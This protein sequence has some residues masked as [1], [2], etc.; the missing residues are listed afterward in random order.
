MDDR[1]LHDYFNQSI[2][3]LTVEDFG[4]TDSP[5]S[6]L[7]TMQAAINY[8][9]SNG[10]QLRAKASEYVIDVSTTGVKIPSGFKCDFNNATIFRNTGN[11]T[12]HDMWAN[13]DPVNGNLGIDIHNV[14]FDGARTA[15]SLNNATVAHRFCGL[16]LI[17]CEGKLTGVRADNTVN[18]EVQVE[19]TRGGI[20]LQSSVFMDCRDIRTDG[21][22]GTGLFITG[23]SGRL[24]NFQSNNNTGSGISGDQPG[25]IMSALS[26]KGSGYSGISLNG[27]GFIAQGIYASGAPV[28]FAGVNFGHATPES[29]NGVN[30]VIS[31]IIVENNSG[32]GINATSCPGITISNWI[33]KG[34]GIN[35]LRLVNC[36]DA[37]ISGKSFSA[38]SNGILIDGAGDYSLDVFVLDSAGSGVY[39]RNGADV[40]FAATSVL[41]HN[42]YIGGFTAE[43]NVDTNSKARF[44]GK[45]FNGLAFGIQSSGGGTVNLDGCVVMGN[46]FGNTRVSGGVINYDRVRFSNDPMS[47]TVVIQAGSLIATVL[48]GNAIDPNHIN[49]EPANSA[50]RAAGQALI[51][52]ITPGLSFSI[53]VSVAAAELLIYRWTLI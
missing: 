41:R 24:I 34:S 1:R 10:I 37:S 26:S 29:S 6:T 52:N 45:A 53:Q 25:W 48:N 14:R 39:V 47:G 16:R 11:K 3:Y 18:A 28:G 9:A 40:V 43:L 20:L 35:N 27:P 44:C 5:T 36:P 23:G 50:A 21:T 51:A 7:V 42:G 38:G 2:D 49:I 19:G 31:D 8:C 13:L 15:D 12:P 17:K 4:A 22:A 46:A 32:W 30:S 33:A